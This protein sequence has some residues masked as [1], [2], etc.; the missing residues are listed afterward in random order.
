MMK[1]FEPKVLDIYDLEFEDKRFRISEF[2]A[3]DPLILSI[4]KIGLLHPPVVTVRDGRFVLVSGWK[5]VSACLKLRM[6]RLPVFILEESDDFKAFMFALYENLTIREFSTLEKAE[7]L[8]RLHAFGLPK[9]RMMTEVM[10]LLHIPPTALYRDGY[11]A[12]ARL[13]P[14]VKKMIAEKCLPF[15]LAQLLAQF[16]VRDLKDMMPL[17]LPLG[18]NKQKE[19]LEDLLEISRRRRI[20]P[21]RIL[22]GPEIQAILRSKKWPAVQKSERVRLALRRKRFPYVTAWGERFQSALKELHW[23][24]RIA[25]ETAPYFETDVMEAAFRF[26]DEKE[27]KARLHDLL[28]VSS[29]KDFPRLFRRPRQPSRSREKPK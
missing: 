5:R 27:F 14:F 3:L 21:G 22:R 7:I 15:S 24:K 13:Q 11:L 23:P 28:E 6:R 10:P 18:Q 16:T 25:V 29:R 4:R 1:N 20:S 2:P 26:K 17:L 12:I 9:S 19:V 8:S